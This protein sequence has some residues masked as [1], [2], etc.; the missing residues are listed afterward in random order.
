MSVE[1]TTMV[2]GFTTR[3]SVVNLVGGLIHLLKANAMAV[4]AIFPITCVIN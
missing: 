2:L 3:R 4:E 1:T